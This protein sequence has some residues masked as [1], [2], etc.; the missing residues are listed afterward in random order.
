MCLKPSLLFVLS[1]RSFQGAVPPLGPFI[2]GVL[3]PLGWTLGQ[4]L[5]QRGSS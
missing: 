3:F 5:L 4:G 1:P 2:K